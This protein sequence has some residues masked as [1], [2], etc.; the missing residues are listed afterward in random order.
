MEPRK[1]ANFQQDSPIGDDKFKLATLPGIENGFYV[2]EKSA[3]T[4]LNSIIS[5]LLCVSLFLLRGV[6]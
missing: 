5:M 3:E 2:F 1:Y 6:L 4:P